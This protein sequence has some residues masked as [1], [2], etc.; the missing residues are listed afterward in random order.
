MCVATLVAAACFVFRVKV[1]VAQKSTSCLEATVAHGVCFVALSNV[2]F[3]HLCCV[4][5][6]SGG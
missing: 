4:H 2:V 1:A 6:V 5:V 3:C